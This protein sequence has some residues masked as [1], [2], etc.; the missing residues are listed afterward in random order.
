MAYQ[1][2]TVA[3]SVNPVTWSSGT[4]FDGYVLILLAMP[5]GYSTQSAFIQG[6]NPVMP[7]AKR[8]RFW[9]SDGNIDQ[10]ST[11]PYSVSIEPPNTAYA[12]YWYDLNDNLI[13]G[14]TSLVTIG[15]SPYVLT[16]PTLTAPASTSVIPAP[17]PVSTSTQVGFSDQEPVQG[18]VNGTNTVFTILFAPSP[19]ASLALFRNGVEQSQG[20]DYSIGSSGNTIN[21]LSTPVPQ[22]GDILRA[23]YRYKVLYGV[24]FSDSET[25]SGTINGTNPTFTLS[26]NPNPTTSLL[27]L[28]NGILQIQGVN[29]TL[30]GN[31]ITFL[32]G[33]I[34]QSGDW[35][36]AWYRY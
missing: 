20:I 33:F 6:Q 1:Y 31:T 23:S 2:A 35:L 8:W 30:S 36:R 24:N 13:A 7:I 27:I 25:P 19:Q 21:W 29:F 18:T 26:W 16:V 28:R 22:T 4:N 9:I 5:T 32:G 3:T 17:A 11:I 10:G 34:P 12:V 15:A 14:P